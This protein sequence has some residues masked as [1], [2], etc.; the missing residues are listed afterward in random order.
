MRVW[1]KTMTDVGTKKQRSEEQTTSM[2]PAERTE[3][4]VRR[5]SE[6]IERSRAGGYY[7][8][9]FS[10]SPSEF[11]TMSPITLKPGQKVVF[12]VRKVNDKR[13]AVNI[14][15]GYDLVGDACSSD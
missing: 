2:T 5:Q 9:I 1:G 10:V 15:H 13:F 12:S 11:F 14:S 4:L 3:G 8:S 7:P 6:W